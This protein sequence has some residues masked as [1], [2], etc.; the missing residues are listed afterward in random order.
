[1]QAWKDPYSSRRLMLLAFLDNRHMK[2][3]RLL[4]L[5]TGRLY[6]QEIFLVFISVRGWIDSRI[7][8]RPEGWNGWKIP[9]TPSGHE[10]A[11]FRLVG[12]CL[13]QLRH[14]VPQTYILHVLVSY[15]QTVITWHQVT[16]YAHSFNSVTHILLDS[17]KGHDSGSLPF[18]PFSRNIFTKITPKTFS[19]SQYTS[20]HTILILFCHQT[21]GLARDPFPWGFLII[22][23]IIIILLLLLLFL[24]AMWFS[25]GG[26][27]LT[28]QYRHHNTITHT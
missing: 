10:P 14:R 16:L 27:S 7:I 23:I 25:P 2:M 17:T 20:P 9:M 18:T 21:V 1:M 22:I 19:H 11:T 13:N 5:R 26:S 4:V 6:P 28:H 3:V 24:T 12:Q 8:V 15:C